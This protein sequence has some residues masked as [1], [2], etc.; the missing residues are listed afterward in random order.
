MLFLT[1]ASAARAGFCHDSNGHTG[2]SSVFF[3]KRLDLFQPLDL[4]VYGFNLL[5]KLQL[6]RSSMDVDPFQVFWHLDAFVECH[7]NRLIQ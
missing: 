5:H 4:H 6:I 1:P 2:K 7:I 3:V